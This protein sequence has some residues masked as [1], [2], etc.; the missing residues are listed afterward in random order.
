[1]SDINKK[2]QKKKGKSNSLSMLNLLKMDAQRKTGNGKGKQKPISAESTMNIGI[3]S[4]TV[5]L[6]Q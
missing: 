6:F 4:E 3:N 2:W 5:K 1:M